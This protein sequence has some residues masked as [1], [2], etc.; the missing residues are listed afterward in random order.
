MALSPIVATP[1]LY[2]EGDLRAIIDADLLARGIPCAV[3]VGEWDAELTRGLPSCFILVGDE[4]LGEPAGHYQPGAWWPV[5]ATV[6]A[7]VVTLNPA[8]TVHPTVTPS[9]TGGPTSSG[10]V[11]VTFTTGGATGAGSLAV[12]ALSLD[13][14]A[15]S[16][17]Y[18][19]GD[20]STIEVLGMVVDLGVGVVTAGDSIAFVLTTEAAAPILDDEAAY[21]LRIH[22][23]AAPGIDSGAVEAQRATDALKR[24]ILAAVRRALGAPFR[25]DVRV[26]WPR[27]VPGYPAFVYG[28]LCEATIT[29]ASP[30]LNDKRPL[31]TGT[32][33][34]TTFSTTFGA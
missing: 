14:G 29:I 20:R 8:S 2:T 31:V 22:S 33:F 34:A 9:V 21:V 13:G 26:T 30:V 18:P 5:N 25:R 3:Q 27:V 23:P 15:S 4:V 32:Q 1:Q 12:Y 11:L 28:S 16:S 6:S 17:T 19:L 7:P 10:N 24:A